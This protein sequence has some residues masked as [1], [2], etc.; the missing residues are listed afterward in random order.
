[1]ERNQPSREIVANMIRTAFDS[2]QLGNGIGLW[3][4]QAID[5]YESEDVQLEARKRDRKTDW[6]LLSKE[7]LQQCG[8]SLCFF[9]CEGMRFH[10]PAFLISE[11]D[12]EYGSVLFSLTQLDDYKRA[13]F[14]AL[15]QEQRRAVT[16]FLE[17]CLSQEV[18]SFEHTE[19]E[20][21]LRE[22]WSPSS[23]SAL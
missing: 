12:E 2:V 21:A 8:S 3:Q 1:M 6:E 19:I 13:M 5:D 16:L 9:D 23:W 14:E 10:L 18:Y 4:A 15:D 7:D 11:L 20:I 22:Y 17:Y